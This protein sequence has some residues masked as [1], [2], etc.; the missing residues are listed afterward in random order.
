MH[1]L[2]LLPSF[3]CSFM[4]QTSCICNTLINDKRQ[5]TMNKHYQQCHIQSVFN[6]LLMVNV[7]RGHVC[8]LNCTKRTF[9]SFRIF[10]LY[11]KEF[12][13]KLQTRKRQIRT[14]YLVETVSCSD[15]TIK[16]IYIVS[17]YNVHN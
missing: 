5:T 4:R 17:L 9:N 8:F 7:H 14:N 6:N 10:F 16:H 15:K 1:L 11:Y 12:Q 13:L 3:G 2:R